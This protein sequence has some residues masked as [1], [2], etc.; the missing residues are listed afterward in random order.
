MTERDAAEHESPRLSGEEQASSEPAGLALVEE[1]G[2]EELTAETAQPPPSKAPVS[3]PRRPLGFVARLT[4]FWLVLTGSVAVAVSLASL[5]AAASQSGLSDLSLTGPV[6]LLLSLIL[7][8]LAFL[9]N[10]GRAVGSLSLKTLGVSGMLVGLVVVA[11]SVVVLLGVFPAGIDLHALVPGYLGLVCA[12]SFVPFLRRKPWALRCMALAAVVFISCLFMRGLR[13]F[14]VW[15]SATALLRSHPWQSWASLGATGLVGIV[16]A[17]I[18]T[19]PRSSRNGRPVR[20]VVGV[21]ALMSL[22]GAAGYATTTWPLKARIALAQSLSML[23]LLPLFLCAVVVAWRRRADL[24]DDMADTARFTW[25]FAALAAVLFV[26]AR[27]P[28]IISGG[29][30]K[31]WLIVLGG[32]SLILAAWIGEKPRSYISRWALIPAVCVVSWVLCMPGA[33][34]SLFA[35]SGEGIASSL[36]LLPIV[37]VWAV[38][39][40][41]SVSAAV[42]MFI[43]A[44]RETDPDR[45]ANL[46]M[47]SN[48]AYSGG[49]ILPG[50]LLGLCFAARAANASVAVALQ[51]SL[52]AIGGAVRGVLTGA[53]GP[54]RAE[55]MAQ[56]VGRLFGAVLAGQDWRLAVIAA[57]LAAIL[58]V[59]VFAAWG[60]SPA[61]RAVAIIWLV[62]AALGLVVAVCMA[63]FLYNPP[64]AE[65]VPTDAG[66]LVA[67]SLAVRVAMLALLVLLLLRLSDVVQAVWR[68]A[69]DPAGD[70]A[71]E[72]TDLVG[73]DEQRRKLPF[74]RMVNLGVVVCCLCVA[75]LFLLWAGANGGSSLLVLRTFGLSLSSRLGDLATRV[76]VLVAARPLYAVAVALVA[77]MS[78]LLHQETRMGRVD[79]YP[80]VAALWMALA[81]A[82]AATLWRRGHLPASAGVYATIV[83]EGKLPGTAV[84][85]I[86]WLALL[87][88]SVCLWTRWWLLKSR[89]KTRMLDEAPP[90]DP[91]YLSGSSRTL[92]G[93]G[94]ALTLLCTAL[95]L[96][97]VVWAS[98]TWRPRLELLEAGCGEVGRFVTHTLT[99]LGV[100]MGT[101]WRSGLSVGGGAIL[102]GLVVILHYLAQ[103]DLRWPRVA[104]TALWTLVPLLVLAAYAYWVD[105]K[106]FGQWNSS[107]ILIGLCAGSVI[108]GLGSVAITCWMRLMERPGPV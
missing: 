26:L 85:V 69:R 18:L 64:G 67:S 96:Y 78:L 45:A 7:L 34:P 106:S 80:W 83:A 103:F 51:S 68:S 66:R 38:A 57:S 13:P 16:L 49:W 52:T 84:L 37:F 92:G 95:V 44:R 43:S 97:S 35:A 89:S 4:F 17:G 47:H 91:S 75:F 10:R 71:S 54:D 14:T 73:I 90:V 93:L 63:A 25:T 6:P 53:V 74:L 41:L 48:L 59:H 61:R 8:G 32:S 31:Q 3:P 50:L 101:P 28:D 58:L 30:L 56:P 72:D 76:G 42:G 12:V 24:A 87:L 108:L 65:V 46:Q 62:V 105:L 9:I 86:V 107:Q 102:L 29:F 70:K 55:W 104:V 100:S 27:L 21:I 82:G 20:I 88:S 81:V 22:L 94:V 5:V 23:G 2:T 1:P 99:L 98:A 33:L 15:L 11:N 36:R 39:T 77:W 60:N 19:L 79:A 40:V